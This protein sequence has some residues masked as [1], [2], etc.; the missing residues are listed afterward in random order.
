MVV[1]I[2]RVLLPIDN[3]NK[4]CY[5]ISPLVAA[6]NEDIQIRSITATIIDNKQ[7]TVFLHRLI[8]NN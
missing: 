8:N 3:L 1:M 5:H 6:I 4:P 2:L 7:Q